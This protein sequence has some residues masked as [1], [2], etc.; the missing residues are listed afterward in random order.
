M[1]LSFVAFERSIG[2]GSSPPGIRRGFGCS[3][4]ETNLTVP[5]SIALYLEVFK[6]IKNTLPS[7]PTLGADP[8][9]SG[10]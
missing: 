5:I 10:V 2:P 7:F 4:E 1:A 8:E 9:L 6:S 3:N